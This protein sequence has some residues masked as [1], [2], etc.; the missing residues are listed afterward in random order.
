MA[1]LFSQKCDICLLVQ[2]EEDHL[3]IKGTSVVMNGVAKFA[4]EPCRDLLHTAF[5]VGAEGIRDPLLALSKMT[6]ERDELRRLLEQS[7]IQREGGT[8]T[9]TGVELDHRVAQ[10]WNKLTPQERFQPHNQLGMAAPPASTRKLDYKPDKK[11]KK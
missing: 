5:S 8:V 7:G 11:K 4:C 9:L 2:T 1:G 3:K 10:A 6:K